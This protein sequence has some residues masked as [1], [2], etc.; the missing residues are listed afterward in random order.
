[1]NCIHL[2][3]FFVAWFIVFWQLSFFSRIGS[4]M[5]MFK[6][7]LPQSHLVATFLAIG[8][9]S[10]PQGGVEAKSKKKIIEESAPSE[11]VPVISSTSNLPLRQARL[12][13]KE[14]GALGPLQLRGVEGDATVNVSVRL[15]E[16]VETAKLHMAFTVSPALLPNLSHI[17]VM[18][19]DEV[20]HTIALDKDKQGTPQVIDL[21]LDPRYFG[22][23]NRLRFQLIGHYT[24]EC[25]FPDHTSLWATVSNESY[26][27]LGLRQ[28]QLKN[29]LALLPA[30][31]F[32]YRDNRIVT[33]PI[34]F[35]AKPTK[36]LL[37]ASG[38][39]ATWMGA[40]AAYRGNRFP[41]LQNA[42]PEQHSI[43]LASNGSRPDFL[44]DF[45]PVNKPTLAVVS[46]PTLPGIKMLLVLGA[47]D[48][49]VQ[50][51]AESLAHSKSAMSG[52]SMALNSLVESPKRE[53]YDAPRWISTK[54][55]VQLGELVQNPGDLQLRGTVLND[56]VRINTHM[57]PDL[58]TWNVKGVPMNL[59]YRYT[60]TVVSDHGMLNLS[61]NDQFI[62]S[63]PLL[64][65]ESAVNGERILLPL[66]SD[67]TVQA[68]SDFRIP[69]HLI[70][71]DNQLQF[72]FQIPPADLGRCRSVRPP[73]LRAAV[74]PQSTIDL[75]GFYHYTAMPNLAAY[76]N[77]GFP[78]TKYAD[79]SETSVVLP[80]DTNSTDIEVY[81]GAVARM[82]ASTGYAGN[83]FK[84]LY[85]N[86]V[87]QAK[88]TDLLVISH[89]DKDHLLSQWGRNMSA[90]LEQGLR[91]VQP[92]DR[93]LGKFSDLF[94]VD[95]D[96]QVGSPN[97]K[98]VLEGTGPLGAIVGLESPLD[99]G[100]SVVVLSA[101][102]AQSLQM[103]GQAINDSSKVLSMRG[104]LAVL[105]GGA[106]E[107]FRTNPVY[108]VGDLPW[109]RRVWFALHR[110]PA[111]LAGVGI[112]SAMLLSFLAFLA[113]RAVA[114]RRLEH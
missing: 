62:K 58:F 71:G 98:A 66:F 109:W 5:K 47:D 6:H 102:D 91:S 89:S 114:R 79:L 33:T 86:E 37:K 95:S 97:G 94:A 41:V 3:N 38:S 99:S 83:R 21:N 51:A 13:L 8:L 48:A 39:I 105:R 42:L 22:D 65:S 9:L 100:R 57:A 11:L 101:T 50:Q 43:V 54:R 59:M 20:L 84:V 82:G 87:E 77:S 36:G 69:T 29:D 112:L 92:L 35:G 70:G 16:V 90:L 31:F 76:A 2:Q 15:D 44:R 23:F 40:L 61:I 25:E 52:E 4:F 17:K 111:L 14:L 27:D 45:P 85:A 1:V 60:P 72:G 113:L 32:D 64:A 74:D 63:Y 30:P 10:I 19:N 46:H 103:V 7:T 80:N 55:P 53:A 110:H 96:L 88:G 24:L 108:Y 34:V 93:V 49:Q 67:S 75:T 18:L 56:V 26:L 107:S 28:V 78:F 12:K 68:K 81:L 73:E 104:D 106:I